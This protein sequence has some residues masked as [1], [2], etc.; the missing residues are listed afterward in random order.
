MQLQKQ[1]DSRFWSKTYGENGHW[2]GGKFMNLLQKFDRFEE[3][4]ETKKNILVKDTTQINIFNESHYI[5]DN[6]RHFFDGFEN[7]LK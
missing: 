1:E 7:I 4:E 6:S 2:R 5:P 3:S